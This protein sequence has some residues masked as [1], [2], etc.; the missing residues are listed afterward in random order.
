MYHSKKDQALL[1]H[2]T[3]CLTERLDGRELDAEAFHRLVVTARA[4][5]VSRPV[6]LVK[7]A[8]SRDATLVDEQRT[9]TGTEDHSFEYCLLDR[10]ADHNVKQQNL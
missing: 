10:P 3:Q 4:V 8:E 1:A 5:A 6:N 9:A 7:F 2:V